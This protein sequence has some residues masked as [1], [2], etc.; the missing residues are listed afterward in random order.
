M[1]SQE[2]GRRVKS[3]VRKGDH[4]SRGHGREGLEDATML[5]LKMEEGAM[6]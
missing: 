1:S 3:R 6:S 5:A 2:G 4:G